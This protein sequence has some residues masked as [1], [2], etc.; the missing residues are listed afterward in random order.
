[1]SDPVERIARLICDELVRQALDAEVLLFDPGS[2]M[3]DG[4]LDVHAIAGKIAE[5]IDPALPHLL[6]EVQ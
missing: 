3:V 1:M 5:A 4:V 6:G 2:G